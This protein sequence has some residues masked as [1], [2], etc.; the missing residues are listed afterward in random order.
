MPV[1]GHSRSCEDTRVKRG[2]SPE[3]PGRHRLKVQDVGLETRLPRVWTFV[4]R[5]EVVS[6]GDVSQGASGGVWRHF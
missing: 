5:A 2:A 4:C 1:W 3:L 6:H